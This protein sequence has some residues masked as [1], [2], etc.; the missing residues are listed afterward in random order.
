M[1][2]DNISTSMFAAGAAVLW[3]GL[4]GSFADKE[5]EF[6]SNLGSKQGK[7]GSA[8]DIGCGTG[9]FLIPLSQRGW[10]V[11]GIDASS[12]MLAILRQKAAK[13]Q[14]IP[15]VFHIEFS[16]FKTAHC[17][18]LILSFYSMIYIRS[19]SSLDSFFTKVRNMLKPGGVFL[20][21]FFNLYEFWNPEGW[22]TD[23]GKI[24]KTGHLRVSYTNDP[25]DMIRG[26]AKVTDLRSLFQ[27][28]QQITD[29]SCRPIRYHSPSTVHF[30][31][32]RA[33]FR[34]IKMYSGF[35][36][37]ALGESDVRSPV[38]TLAAQR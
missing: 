36:N 8:L 15:S 6:V 3:D 20:V 32:K 4:Y 30:F 29:L 23:M 13:K 7:Q 28:G 14:I 5:A 1:T 31:L 19:D 37:K 24:F 18:D 25:F 27:Q 2:S 21:N 16:Q 22:K 12:D 33:G 11:T 26:V 34:E 38:I 35:E 10:D 17:Y 9:R